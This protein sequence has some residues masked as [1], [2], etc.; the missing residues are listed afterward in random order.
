MCLRRLVGK[1][2]QILYWYTISL[3]F[4][5]FFFLKHKNPTVFSS[6]KKTNTIHVHVLCANV[7]LY[8]NTF[9]L[10]KGALLT[11]WN[12][13][14]LNFYNRTL[15]LSYLDKEVT[16]FLVN[17]F[18]KKCSK[19]KYTVYNS[20]HLKCFYNNE[21]QTKVEINVK[22]FLYRNVLFQKIFFYM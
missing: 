19:K 12:S 17:S 4:F 10:P 2:I 6:R 14:F 3:F 13:Y 5:F 20:H 16:L 18:K 21:Y 7:Y 22:L 15:R 8:K 11:K 9:T 1:Q